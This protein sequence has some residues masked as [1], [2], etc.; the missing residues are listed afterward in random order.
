M[1]ALE[2]VKRETDV[3]VHDESLSKHND[4]AVAAAEEHSMSIM[5]VLRN[6]KRIVWWCFFFSMSACGWGFDAQVN[7]A[8]ISVPSFRL[9]FGFLTADGPVLAARWQSAFNSCSSVGQFFGGFLCSWVSDRIGR[10]YAMFI[11]LVL[12]TG[13][14]FGEVFSNTNAQFLISKIIL[15]FGLGFYLTIGPLYAS[16]ISP[17]VLRGVTTAGVNFAIVIGQLVSN[18]AIKGF[19]DRTDTWAYKGPFA[20]Q[21]LFVAWIFVGL[22]FVPE[23]PWYYVRHN[24]LQ[25][26]EKSLQ[27]LYGPGVDVRPKLAIIV[28]TVEEDME[29]QGSATWLQCFQGTNLSRTL[30][31]C[32]VFACQHFTGIIFVLG[33]STY[34]FELAG[35]SDSDA[36]SLG[37][38][39][40]STGVVGNLISW[41]VL[42]H[43]GRRS[44]FIAG[45]I[46][47][48]TVLFLIGIMDV[49]PTGA[50]KWVQAS[51]TVVYALFYQMS[52]GAI[53]FSI[54][55]ETSSSSLRAKTMGL[56]T[57]TQSVFGTVINIVVPYL[58]NPDEAHLNGKVG[59]I[60]GGLSLLATIGCFFWIP[61]LKGRTFDE[62]DYMY[63]QGINPRKMGSYVFS[64]GEI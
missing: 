29:L 53:A 49:I 58:V 15:G 21:W 51:L 50:A 2:D 6:N 14:I 11:G 47:L 8:M 25:D 32:G 1:S 61:E 39:V 57:A 60:F 41:Y 22:P 28:K 34:F 54:L 7:G 12:A 43:F 36:F 13:G 30:V 19:G 55:G 24:R 44:G 38:G 17:V 46:S 59:F 16:E 48:T 23:S 5:D 62:I 20:I 35:L 18:A 42:Q 31:S 40:T 63:A 3:A 37:V 52:I 33:F 64:N 9:K 10:K 56:A 4:A 45:M 27:K 26:A